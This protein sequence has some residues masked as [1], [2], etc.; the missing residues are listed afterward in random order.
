MS[1]FFLRINLKVLLLHPLFWITL[2]AAAFVA[3][4]LRYLYAVCL[5]KIG[6]Q[7]LL[8]NTSLIFLAAF[9]AAWLSLALRGQWLMS[10]YTCGTC[11]E[12]DLAWFILPAIKKRIPIISL[13]SFGLL[14]PVFYL[15]N[16][17]K[18]ILRNVLQFSVF[19]LF[20]AASLSPL[21]GCFI[22]SPSQANLFRAVTYT[23]DHQL[24]LAE[25]EIESLLPK[26]ASNH[27]YLPAVINCPLTA[28]WEPGLNY[29]IAFIAARFCEDGKQ[30]KVENWLIK[31]SAMRK[32][33]K[34][35]QL[36]MDD[37]YYNLG[38]S[39]YNDKQ[40]LSAIIF[41]QKVLDAHNL[42]AISEKELAENGS[43]RASIDHIIDA[44]KA[45]QQPNK[46]ERLL[47]TLLNHYDTERYLFRPGYQSQ[48]ANLLD[49]KTHGALAES[50][51]QHNV[52]YYEK[53]HND[54]EINHSL[55]D[56]GNYYMKH[57]QINNA[58]TIFE[59][60][61]KRLNNQSSSPM[62][63]SSSNEIANWLF[64]ARPAITTLADA[65]AHMG[66]VKDGDTLYER[67]DKLSRISDNRDTQIIMTN[68]KHIGYF[69]NLHRMDEAK[70]LRQE[71][72]ELGKKNHISP[73]L[74]P[75]SDRPNY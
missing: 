50:L 20:S 23:R 69:E 75:L 32:G 42:A 29:D 52:L 17:S 38:M 54:Y 71:N 9:L 6:R 74:P 62:Q 43:L 7:T 12:E 10:G 8:I 73:E 57:G 58:V 47:Q 27:G 46:A 19:I 48:L 24:D 68:S 37:L 64:E 45:T 35:Y 3:W 28:S 31:I 66:R 15:Q 26:L 18:T 55:T 70:I 40:Y 60:L 36:S 56:L 61:V 4:L 25:K 49:T 1:E 2:C 33:T 65:Y 13:I 44:W 41:F 51:L 11:A 21:Y 30:S 67:L 34:N 5:R 39:L 53:V 14:L 63:S 22:A 72:I 59:K 16:S